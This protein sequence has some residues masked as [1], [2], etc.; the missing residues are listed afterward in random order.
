MI[1]LSGRAAALAALAVTVLAACGSEAPAPTAAPDPSST[2]ADGFPLEIENCG[3]TLT[4]DEP[5]ARVVASYHPMA[6]ML[7]GLGLTDRVVGRAAADG[8]FGEANAL[9]EQ[10][11]DL[12]RIPVVSDTVYPPPREQL[13]ALRPD[14]LFAY[15]DFD[16]GGE[17]AGA[18]GLATLDDL[19][20][21][22]VQV[23]TVTCPDPTGNYAGETLESAYR[24]ISDL[25]RIFDVA[26]QADARVEEMQ[27]QIADVQAR[28][29]SLPPVS[30]LLYAGGTG[31]L[32]ISG[33]IGI[34]NEILEAAGGTNVFDAEGL[35]FQASLESV[36]ATDI[37]AYVVFA[38]DVAPDGTPDVTA[39]SEFLFETFPNQRASQERQ[40]VGTAFELTAPGWRNA[41]TVEYIARGLHPEAFE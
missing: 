18:D 23:Y 25:G 11:A 9:P 19:D 10:A 30:A 41:D 26:D 32:D 16:Y 7:V 14:L 24:S 2:S 37:G 40:V 36:A 22:G 17:G 38:E 31:P 1:S 4:F 20:A 12:A 27:Q 35:Y 33:G 29:A 39:Q 21:A 5:P 6:E 13:L 28:V 8:A 15:G 3:R 34:N